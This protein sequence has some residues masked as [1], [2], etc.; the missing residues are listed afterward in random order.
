M[1]ATRLVGLALLLPGCPDRTISA[2][3]PEQGSVEVK[4]FPAVPRRKI[5]I[6]FQIDSSGSMREEQ[7][8]LRA[9]FPRFIQVL[10]T[11]DGGLPDVHIGVI[12]PDMGGSALDGTVAGDIGGCVG[13]G[14]DGALRQLPGD[15]IRF[16]ADEI[17]GGGNRVP[18]YPG[19]LADAF[20]SLADVGFDGCGIEQHLEATRSALDGHPSNTGFVRD[21]AY[22][23]IV[24]IADE[25][26]C[27]LARSAITEGIP[28]DAGWGDAV[29]FRCTN[30][31][32]VCDSP[33]IPFHDAPGTRTDCRPKED[34]Q[35]IA[36]VDRYV[37]FVKGIKPD[38]R[39]V[40]VAGIIGPQDPFRIGENNGATIL[41]SSCPV[42]TQFAIPAV[43]TGA[44]L[45]QFEQ[46]NTQATICDADLSGGLAQ[47][48]AAIKQLPGD[49]CFRN[50]LTD[51]DL[52][53]PGPQY[54]CTI[55]E[56]RRNPGGDDV[57][58]G[59]IPPCQGGTGTCW[60]IEED[61]V[62]CFYTEADPHLKLVIDR[63]GAAPG[64]DVFIKAQCVTTESSGPAL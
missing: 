43:R 35:L 37:D 10:E 18:N 3:V 49:R 50:D 8:S 47:I 11:I 34:S 20:S 54:G 1:Q 61:A 7:A 51:V 38:S 46:R 29:N 57:E 22:L 6:L 14:K 58:L 2:V 9:N 21:D 4:D 40:F 25:D 31:G 30:E 41:E 42:A 26:D 48:A 39:D 62:E 56:Y 15:T 5:D 16:L 44:F 36:P 23:A 45:A 28:R 53:S 13:S 19:T 55:T 17:D 64:S 33:A 24:I 12:T 27:S 32:V 59:V 60:R 52:E 63:V